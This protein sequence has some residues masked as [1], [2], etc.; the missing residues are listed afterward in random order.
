MN[1]PQWYCQVVYEAESL[2]IGHGR[3]EGR[4]LV[5]ISALA[6]SQIWPDK[7]GCEG[8]ANHSQCSN[9]LIERAGFSRGVKDTERALADR[10]RSH[11]MKYMT[12]DEDLNRVKKLASRR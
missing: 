6:D 12:F 10:D 3:I 9:E 2:N 4:E 7:T 5:A 11:W 8:R 1:E